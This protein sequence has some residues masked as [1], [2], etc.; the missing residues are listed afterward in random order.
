[1]KITLGNKVTFAILEMI[2]VSSKLVNIKQSDVNIF[3]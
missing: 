1:M 2:S 3:V